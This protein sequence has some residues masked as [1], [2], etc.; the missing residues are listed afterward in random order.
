MK[1]TAFA[2]ALAIG[3]LS[4]AFAQPRGPEDAERRSAGAGAE[5]SFDTTRDD[6]AEAGACT[7]RE[8]PFTGG[9]GKTVVRLDI[10][11]TI[12]L[13]LS[14]FV[15]R[16]LEEAEEDGAALV[17]LHMDTPGGRLDAAQSIKD[18]LLKSKVPTA[19]FIDTHALSAGAL[20]AYATDFIVVTDGTTMGAATPINVGQGGEAQP[21]GEKFVSAVRAIFRA[22]AEAKGR[23]GRIAEAMVDK[24]VV[25]FDVIEKDKLLTLS[26]EKL[27]KLCVADL[28][29]DDVDGVLKALN[30]EGAEL[31]H[32]SL[33]WA[34][35]IARVLTDPMVS[36]MLMSFGF[37]GLMLEMY[38]AGFGAA[39]IIGAVCLFLFFFGHLVV[40]LV[41]V[42]ELV[43]FVLGVALLGAEIFVIPGFGLAGVAGIAALVGAVALSLVGQDLSFSW[44]VGILPD[45]LARTGLAMLATIV[46]F[47][48]LAKYLPESRLVGRLVLESAVE[49]HSFSDAD[50]AD[51]EASLVGERGRTTT[52]VRGSGKAKI[53]G[54][55]RD[56]VNEGEAI[57]RDVEVVVIEAR[58][59]RIVVAEPT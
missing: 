38:T 50:D 2:L 18:A 20:I 48:A 41:G 47:A 14:P 29:A 54:E 6:A 46:I 24:D 26:K 53:A 23:D 27:V 52:P 10:H 55:V 58:K 42:E 51:D 3:M 4:H 1:R 32:R 11:K 13:G 5:E 40:N 9:A 57:E 35:R 12:D 8:I 25:I 28:V 44:D 45:A 33:N 31:E 19:T 21:V 16:V 36:G 34:E 15:S 37:L 17:L 49:G 59:G 39:G 22:T 56:V 43:L 30:L 7:P